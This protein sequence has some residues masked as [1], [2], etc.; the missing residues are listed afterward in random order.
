MTVQFVGAA[1]KAA[2][3]RLAANLLRECLEVCASEER[4]AHVALTGGGLG[5]AMLAALSADELPAA[6]W[7]NAHFWWGDERFAPAD[8]PDRNSRQAELAL[9]DHLPVPA[10]H[11]HRVA[12]PESGDLDAATAAYAAELAAHG[13]PEGFD[14]VF[15]GVGPD[16]HI[17]SLFP[18]HAALAATGL[19]VAE[20]ASPKPPAQRVSLTLAALA[21]ARVTVFLAAGAEKAE[22]VRQV[23][24]GGSQLPAA[25]LEE[26][27]TGATLWLVDDASAQHLGQPD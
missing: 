6:T 20:P 5:I 1:D 17:A 8:H 7:A 27:A 3:A 13:P 16:G 9:L 24:A 21:T 2:A 4:P 26:Q 22:V 12:G 14:I 19:T 15:L 10:A 25:L 23:A 18:G 11:V